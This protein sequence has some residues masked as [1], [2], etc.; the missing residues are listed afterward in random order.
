[1]GNRAP[2]EALAW[3]KVGETTPHV[4]PMSAED[5]VY[6][7]CHPCSFVALARPEGTDGM[8]PGVARVIQIP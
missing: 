7:G 5:V 1:V 2:V 6:A 8:T 3:S 4:I